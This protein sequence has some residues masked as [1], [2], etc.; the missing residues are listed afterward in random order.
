MIAICIVLN[1]LNKGFFQRGRQMKILVT[2]GAGYI[3]SHVCVALLENGHEVV[4]F[5]NLVNSRIESL[6]RVE[7]ITGKKIHFFKGDIRDRAALQ[8][9]FEQ[10]HFDLVCHL[11]AW[12]SVTESITH[13]LNYYENNVSG[14]ALLL[15]MMKAYHVRKIIFGSSI[16]IY[17]ENFG[18][19]VNEE[20]EKCFPQN[21]YLA[22]KFIGEQ[23]IKDI[24]NS[25]KGLQAIILEFGNPA[26][27]HESGKIGECSVKN[28]NN[29]FSNLFNSA[30]NEVDF[31]IYGTNYETKDGTP[32]RDYVHIS[33]LVNGHIKAIEYID[34]VEGAQVFLLCAGRGYSVREVVDCFQK[35][36]GLELLVKEA[37][38]RLGDIGECVGDYKKAEQLL[39][40]KPTKDLT[41]ICK[42]AWNWNQ[43]YPQGYSQ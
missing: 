19:L 23:L 31:S 32:I 36:N 11:A 12:K 2:G 42:D 8:K 6:N 30:L 9:V 25:H 5:D 15:R 35:T 38:P 22:T 14:T 21:P 33:D 4:V 16:G 37:N 26:G 34:K 24:C 20:T 13:P 7:E 28:G 43:N 41:Q 17:G 39:G 40:W 29:L 10:T 3:G 18:K 27:A 1:F